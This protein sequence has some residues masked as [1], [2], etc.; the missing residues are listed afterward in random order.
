M[1]ILFVH[2]NMPGQFRHLAPHLARDPRNRVVFITK[3][4]RVELPHVRRVTYQPVRAAQPSTHHYLRS[5]ENCVLHGQAVL[6]AGISLAAAGF[7]PDVIVGHP[8][9]GELMFLKDKFH[10]AKLLNYC[11]FFY[12][13]RGADVGFD[14]EDRA[15][16]DDICQVRI[17]NA[18]L[19]LSLVACDRGISPTEWQ[20]S[21]HPALLQDKISVI[22]DGIDTTTVCPDRQASFT[23]PN[24]RVL[25]AADE[26][27]TYVTRN[28]E[29]YRGFRSFMRALPELLRRRPAAHVLVVGG[30]EVGYG[31]PAP[32]GRTWRETMLQEVEGLDLAR[33]HFLGKIP[34]AR[35][36]AMLQV[37]SVH[38]YLTVPFVL[39]WSCLEA[40]AAGCVVVASD[41][42]PVTE[43]VED[44]RNGYLVDFFSP[45]AIAT[46]VA[47]VVADRERL[48]SIRERARETVLDRYALENCLPLQAELVTSL[49]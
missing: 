31:T 22:F 49:A 7:E 9:W 2:Q 32:G 37:S 3:Q 28:L 1:N 12:H 48:H 38:V 44:G 47:E 20:R 26:V 36:L 11:E 17:K 10:R 4:D 8:G 40:M 41:T 6:R 24:G 43:V 23:L 15:E 5:F 21:T 42:P 34:Y 39:S 13:G 46:R 33:V 25:T 18:H 30:D 14:P 19:L 35:Y 27:V 16:L 45:H 29:P